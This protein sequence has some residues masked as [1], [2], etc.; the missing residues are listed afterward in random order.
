MSVASINGVDIY[1]ETYGEGFP[2]IFSHEFAGDSQSWMPQVNY[3]SRKYKVITY[4]D[5]GYPPS[6]VPEGDDN[7][8]QEKSL[9]DLHG[10]LNYLDIKE[11]YIAGLSMGGGLA[12][13]FGIKYPQI[14]KAL[15]IAGAG[16]GSDNS[17]N[18]KE[19][20]NNQAS[21]M[22]KDFTSWA[23]SY[24]N[25][26]Q[27]LQYKSKDPKGWNIFRDALVNHSP[28]GSANTFKNVQGKRK[29]IYE[30]EKE[31]EKIDIP[32]LIIVGDEDEPCINPGIFLKNKMKNAGLVFVPK[33][34]HTVN[35]EEPSLFNQLIDEF[36]S[37]VEN[38][39]W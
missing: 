1:Y 19:S 39:T 18:W 30:L 2:I 22:E 24:A 28:L 23:D 36:L 7:Y 9:E 8:S 20:V 38:N 33:T 26:P 12:V 31:I 10:L 29:T 37:K 34:G 4:N 5:R 35:L 17:D 14:A 13:S 27:R 11:A 6:S 3:F 25:G 15:I 21:L 32:S 16:S